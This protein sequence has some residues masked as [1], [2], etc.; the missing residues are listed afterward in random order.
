MSVQALTW[1]LDHSPAI[2]GDRLVLISIANHAD[3]EGRGSYPPVAMIASEARMSTR[4]V[5]YA[6]RSLEHGFEGSGKAI[7]RDGR[8]PN[9]ATLWAV[10]MDEQAKTFR[11]LPRPGGGADSA[12]PAVA[13]SAPP[14]AQ[15]RTPACSKPSINRHPPKP[16]TAES[17]GA[18]DQ[19]GPVLVPVTASGRR[20][21]V[22]QLEAARRDELD[23]W[24]SQHPATPEL[25]TLLVPVFDA[26]RARVEQASFSIWISPLHVHQAI[27]AGVVL[28]TSD[29]LVGW[30]EQRY[31]A[32][33]AELLGRPVRVIECG[34]PPAPVA[35]VEGRAA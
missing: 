19:L 13:D 30:T 11:G 27:E 34:C 14:G 10:L 29:Q 5:Q 20:R 31:G 18:G 8:G 24:L 35:A 12:P 15:D 23:A 4:N 2:H 33:L 3:R 25:Q 21:E 26:L 9:G 17:R 16:P 28:G 6:L 7:F 22:E 1:V 32:V